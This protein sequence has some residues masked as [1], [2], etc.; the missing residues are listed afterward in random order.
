MGTLLL[1]NGFDGFVSET[2][3]S[4]KVVMRRIGGFLRRRWCRAEYYDWF[5]II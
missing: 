4:G 1:A 5:G 3:L 2:P